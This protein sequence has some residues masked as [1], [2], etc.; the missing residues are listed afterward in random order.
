MMK[1]KVFYEGEADAIL[2]GK[3]IKAMEKIGYQWYAQ[4]YNFKKKERDLAFE[5]A[6]GEE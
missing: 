2:D 4:G 1:L 3:I 6:R 5:D